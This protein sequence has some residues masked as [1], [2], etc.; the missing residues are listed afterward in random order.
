MKRT[1]RLVR[2]FLVLTVSMGFLGS[3]ASIPELGVLYRM[4]QPTSRLQGMEVSLVIQDA[5]PSKEILR[6]GAKGV[7]GV[8]SGNISYSLARFNEKGF[9]IGVFTLREALRKSFEKRLEA[10]GLKVVS[11]S[12]AQ[13]PKI[14]IVVEELYLDY[15]DRRW[16]GEMA[17]EARVVKEGQVLATQHLTGKAERIRIMGRK[18]ADRVMGDLITD[19]VN[20]LDLVKL[21][22]QARLLG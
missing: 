7:F 18:G 14:V 16:V 11:D 4:P 8:F 17:Y 2:I 1:T 3:C 19:M 5:R 22:S 10:E 15:K 13:V 21:F 20:R 12:M 6:P 9:K